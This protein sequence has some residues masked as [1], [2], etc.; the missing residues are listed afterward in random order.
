MKY[1]A[2]ANYRE[3]QIDWLN[4]FGLLTILLLQKMGRFIPGR[5]IYSMLYKERTI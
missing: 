1:D 2:T 5:F 3:K 4:S